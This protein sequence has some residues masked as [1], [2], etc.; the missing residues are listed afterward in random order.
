LTTSESTNEPEFPVGLTGRGRAVYA[1]QNALAADGDDSLT[2][3]DQPT[4]TDESA[5]VQAGAEQTGEAEAPDPAGTPAGPADIPAPPVIET[6]D[7]DTS[8]V[9]TREG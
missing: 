6:A 9:E 7:A 4:G 8:G 2:L 5:P 1:G 3:V